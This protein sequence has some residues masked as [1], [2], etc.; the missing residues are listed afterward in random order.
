MRKQGIPLSEAVREFSDPDEL[1]EL[2]RLRR[3]MWSAINEKLE[4]LRKGSLSAD[5][6]KSASSYLAHAELGGRLTAAFLDKLK[7]GD[8]LATGYFKDRAGI[9]PIPRQLWET[10][11]PSFSKNAASGGGIEIAGILVADNQPQT[12]KKEKTLRRWF[13]KK[14]ASKYFPPSKQQMFTE[15]QVELGGEISIRAFHRIWDECAPERWRKPGR[16]SARGIRE[17]KA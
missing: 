11:K 6:S 9:S 12:I 7:R 5:T 8:L 3:K 13:E 15:A 10:L 1:E 16:K 2:E 4:D 17:L 14:I